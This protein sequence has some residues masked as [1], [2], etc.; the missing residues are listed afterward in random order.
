MTY[1]PQ[2]IARVV[3][4]AN[5]A[6][7]IEQA[8]PTISVSP[9]W[10][11]L[12]AETRASAVDGVRVVQGGASPRESHENWT[13]FK[14]EHG[15]TLGP[16][17]DETKKEHPLLVSYDELPAAQQDKDALFGA[18]VRALTPPQPIIDI[19]G[20]Y[21]TDRHGN[22]A[23]VEVVEGD[24]IELSCSTYEAEDAGETTHLH[25]RP[26]KARE[27]AAVLLA[28]ADEAES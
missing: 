24:I 7:Q 10:D 11:D 1:S 16:V 21:V 25:F 13:R 3:H 5:R 22:D 18:V 20:H 2:Q 9:S 8:D 15:W 12:N 17:K 6:L 4:E 23:G 14:L 27:L 28:K 19:T 26:A